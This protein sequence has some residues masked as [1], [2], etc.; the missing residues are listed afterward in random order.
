MSSKPFA[1]EV[2]VAQFKVNLQGPSL[3]VLVRSKEKGDALKSVFL[4]YTNKIE[5]SIVEDNEVPGAHD[6]TVERADV[7]GS[8]R[9]TASRIC[10][11]VGVPL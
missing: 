3:G 4:N 11:D 6:K 1:K 9:V 7:R 10:G 8:Y 2:Y 5:F